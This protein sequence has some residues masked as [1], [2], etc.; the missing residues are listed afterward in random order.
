MAEV[1]QKLRREVMEEQRKSR[2]QKVLALFLVAVIVIVAISLWKYFTAHTYSGY[3]VISEFASVGNLKQYQSTGK[4]LILVSNDGAKAVS[5]SGELIWEVLYQ[6]DN[7]S[8][9]FCG[10]VAAVAD[11]GGKDV[12]VIAE[13][14]IPYHYQVLYPIVKLA[15]AEQ[16][17]TAVMLD[18][19]AEDYIQLYDI[20]GGLRVDINTKTKTEGFPVDFALSPDGKKLVT[21]Y[22]T[23]DGDAMISKITFYNAGEVGKNYIGNVVGQRSFEEDIF[24]GGVKFINNE[25]ICVLKE[26][27]FALY[28]MKETPS[29]IS[30]KD[31]A[32]Q[33]YDIVC[34]ESGVIAVTEN[35]QTKKKTLHRFDNNGKETATW[36]DLPD[37]ETLTATGEEVI[38]F[39]PQKVVIYRNN[40]SEKFTAEFERN[41]EAVLPAGGNRYFFLDTGHVRAVKL[42]ES[43]T[44]DGGQ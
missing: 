37:Y 14:G 4:N 20:S 21:L 27:G 29:L 28:H 41:L 32:E 30:E 39:S 44:K 31:F 8:A 33:L 17:V 6:L 18:G 19:G 34:T 43:E 16:G 25:V 5:A 24:V 26:N 15:V 23:F 7:P 36:K 42:S 10:N 40:R 11:V 12:H 3:D 2:I 35:A 22:L 38:F 1:S 9:A 13:N